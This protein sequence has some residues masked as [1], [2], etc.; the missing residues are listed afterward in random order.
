MGG[1][2]VWAGV[3]LRLLLITQEAGRVAQWLKLGTPIVW[4][5]EHFG[6]TWRLRP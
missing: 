1:H 4:V 5:P 6:E 2:L 3:M